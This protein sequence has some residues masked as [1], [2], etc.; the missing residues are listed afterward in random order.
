[1][2]ARVR[3]GLG[4]LAAQSMRDDREAYQKETAL[5]IELA[6]EAEEAGF[7]SVWVT[8]HHVTDDGY[9]PAPL[10][11]LGA[12]AMATQRV[13]LG[14]NVALAPLFQPVRLAEEAAFLDQLCQGRLILGLGLGY[15]PEE[16]AAFGFNVEPAERVARMLACLDVLR[17]AWSGDVVP[18]GAGVQAVPVRPLPWT[19]GGPP[20]W[21]GAW[22]EAGV[23]R[24]R[25][26]GDGYIAPIGTVKDLGRRLTWL[27]EEGGL[28]SFPV[29][30]SLNGFVGGDDAWERVAPGVAHVLGSYRRWYGA[31]GDPAATGRGRISAE[32]AG[33]PPHFVVG[34]PDQCVAAL[35]PLCRFLGSNAS[36]GHLL[37]RLAFPGLS[38]DDAIQS[39]RLF[40][41]EVIPA[42]RESLPG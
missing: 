12:L 21:L 4:G 36:E 14:T 26:I 13:H 30:I 41:T 33:P 11:A 3:F 1:V 9:L 37:I 2:A 20:I 31:S 35:T 22:V 28:D 10:V 16:F 5:L 19:R 23:R 27:R 18:I 24:A 7:D 39:V 32:T 34:T 25:R 15:R 6:R 8:E 42:L 38:R 17:S 29:A 40:G